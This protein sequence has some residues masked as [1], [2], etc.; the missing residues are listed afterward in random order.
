MS[1]IRLQDSLINLDLIKKV[2]DVSAHAYTE[3][4]HSD[5]EWMSFESDTP[6]REAET[7]KR[8]ATETNY[9]YRIMYCIKIWYLG[10]KHPNFVRLGF[11]RSDAQKLYN[12]FATL[13]N[14]NNSKIPHLKID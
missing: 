5:K 10:E 4:N 3:K 14:G 7:L 1:Y 11:V 2:D 12:E 6:S 9:N 8:Y 13:L